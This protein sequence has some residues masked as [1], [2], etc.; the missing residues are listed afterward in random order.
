MLVFETLGAY[1]TIRGCTRLENYSLPFLMSFVVVRMVALYR[2]HT[3]KH[4]SSACIRISLLLTVGVWIKVRK[5]STSLRICT[6]GEGLLFIHVGLGA[7]IK[8]ESR[9]YPLTVMGVS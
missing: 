5:T 8:T 7:R 9:C 6:H 4:D 1:D 3:P 2:A